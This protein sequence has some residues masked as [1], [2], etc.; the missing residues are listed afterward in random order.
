M[1][2]ILEEDGTEAIE[3][4]KKRNKISSLYNINL[5]FMDLNMKIMNGDEATKQVFTFY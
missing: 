5:I 4:F 1:E 3:T 2:I